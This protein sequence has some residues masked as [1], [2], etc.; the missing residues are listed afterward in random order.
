M[1]GLSFSA[2][3]ALISRFWQ[4]HDR[5][6]AVMTWFFEDVCHFTPRKHTIY[7]AIAA[8]WHTSCPICS[9]W[10]AWTLGVLFGVFVAI[11]FRVFFG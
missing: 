11:L 7:W 2:R 8:W 5:M 3:R 9:F 10:R 4:S 6:E 1:S